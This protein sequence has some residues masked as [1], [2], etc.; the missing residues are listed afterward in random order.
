MKVRSSSFTASTAR[1]GVYVMAS[2]LLAKYLNEVEQHQ[3]QH[4]I[5]GRHVLGEPVHDPA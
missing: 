5:Y 2:A 3:R 4:V 1:C